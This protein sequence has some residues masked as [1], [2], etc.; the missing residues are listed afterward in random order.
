MKYNKELDLLING[1]EIKVVGRKSGGKNDYDNI[2][3]YENHWDAPDYPGC[4]TWVR[5]KSFD[6]DTEVIVDGNPKLSLSI[7]NKDTLEHYF[8]SEDT[9]LDLWSVERSVVANIGGREV[10][11][12]SDNVHIANSRNEYDKLKN[13]DIKFNVDGSGKMSEIIS[14]LRDNDTYKLSSDMFL[15]SP[16]SD[17]LHS[18]GYDLDVFQ[19]LLDYKDELT[20][21]G[22]NFDEYISDLKLISTDDL[23]FDIN[24]VDQMQNKKGAI[25]DIE[26]ILSDDVG[27]KSL[28][29]ILD[30]N[31]SLFSK[32]S[33]VINKNKIK[34]SYNNLLQDEHDKRAIVKTVMTSISKDEILYN[35]V[36][37][38]RASYVSRAVKLVTDYTGKDL[39][40]GRL[41]YKLV[42]DAASKLGRT[43]KKDDMLHLNSWVRHLKSIQK[44]Q[45]FTPQLHKEAFHALCNQD[46]EFI[47][48]FIAEDRTNDHFK[49]F[50]N[51]LDYHGLNLES[52]YKDTNGGKTLDII[53]ISINN[54]DVVSQDIL[55]VVDAYR[56]VS[57]GKMGR[58]SFCSF[59][60]SVE[61]AL[62]K[63]SVYENKKVVGNKK[64]AVSKV[65]SSI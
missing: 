63:D 43:L 35:K 26:S 29:Y 12:D 34:E 57:G 5:L 50:S 24:T 51:I 39:E 53:D 59:V 2:T 58:K 7:Y 60:L 16:F 10:H 62:L 4:E 31:D 1:F 32:Y 14:S 6:I 61:L 30:N 44:G 17:L 46:I 15:E 27:E 9:P 49:R 11:I 23:S 19:V 22:I 36:K 45:D 42:E 65:S 21:K 47:S 64:S 25:K 56:G 18:S 28:R 3:D 13:K 40:N 8:V 41:Q 55:H 54:S 48:N 33:E 38:Y 52:L 37:E 20:K